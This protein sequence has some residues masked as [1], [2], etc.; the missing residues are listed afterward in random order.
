MSGSDFFSPLKCAIAQINPV[1]GDVSGNCAL[2]EAEVRAL[3][4]EG[5]DLVVFS[6]LVIS[7]YP[8]EDLVY[9]TAFLDDVEAGVQTLAQ[10]LGDLACGVLVSAPWRVDGALYNAAL[11]LQGGQVAAVRAKYDLPN[12]GVFDEKR[13]FKAGALPAP[14]DFNGAAL[15]VMTCE[16]MW[17]PTV[18]AHLK[19]QGAQILIVL[20]ASPYEIGKLDQRM[21]HALARVAE[22]GLPLIYS[23][24]VG[25]QDEIVFDGRSFT[26]AADGRIVDRMPAFE[27]YRAL[28]GQAAQRQ[29]GEE[30]EQAVLYQALVQGLRDY[31]NKNGF[32]GVLLGLSGGVDSALSAVI[33][34]D[35][36]GAERV[37]CVMMPSRYTSQ[38]SLDDA[39]ALAQNL[40]IKLDEISIADIV[41]GYEAALPSE[42][43]SIMF[44]NIQ[45]RARGVVLMAL[46]NAN[47]KMVLS[48]GNKSEMAVGY[49]TIY[50]DMC[51]GYNVLKD[52]YKTQ[53]YDLCDWRNAQGEAPVIPENI[54]TKAPTAEL[55]DNQTDQDSLPAYAILD[56]ILY[57]L[58][59]RMQPMD[60]IACETG[61]D[62]SEIARVHKMLLRAEYKRRQAPPGVKVSACAF[63]RE[64]RYPITNGFVEKI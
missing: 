29:A 57:R 8:P 4:A 26:V 51:G 32:P 52:L 7:G 49:A 42:A 12:Y 22:T 53:V 21:T 40:G 24:Q 55:R 46:S 9:R 27:P 6:E 17:S 23:N 41:E 37:Q 43:P 1:V 36:L 58:I 44:E 11:L 31:I 19:A 50:G 34:V 63:G 15:G 38:A 61:Y 16:D 3:V 30:D 45:S 25:G 10:C 18:A 2:V 64:R 48:T 62:M 33:A 20:N 14:I 28:C 56:D 13:V 35:A 60:A 54:L 59:E 39:T 47:G 5:A